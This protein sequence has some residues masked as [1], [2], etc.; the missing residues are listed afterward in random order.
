MSYVLAGLDMGTDYE[1]KV[2]IISENGVEKEIRKVTRK[3]AKDTFQSG[4][5]YAPISW[6]FGYS[7]FTKYYIIQYRPKSSMV[8]WKEVVVNATETGYVL[9]GLVVGIEYEIKIL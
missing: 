2:Y 6:V 4:S 3:P 8:G 1:I 7:A 9:A 5:G